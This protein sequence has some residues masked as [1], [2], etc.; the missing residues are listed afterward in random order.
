M[1]ADEVDGVVAAWARERSDLDLTPMQVMSRVARLGQRLDRA[2]SD[3]FA[4]HELAGWEFDVLAALRR[5]G[6][7]YRLSPGRL[8]AET[9]VT[10]GTMTNRV[11]RLAARGLVEREPD[12]NDRRGVLVA[13]TP[14]GRQAVDGA[15]T[16]LLERERG[17]LDGLSAADQRTVARLLGALLRRFEAG[18]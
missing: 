14:R 6:E 18:P 17:L 12:P 2:R 16:D 8:L 13:L 11:D 15:L 3:A 10:S 7:P 1:E 4:A 5:S 9:H